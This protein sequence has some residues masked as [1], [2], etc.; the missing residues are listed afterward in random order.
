MSVPTVPQ[1]VA[2]HPGAHAAA[3]ARARVT[4]RAVVLGAVLI[5]LNVY[6]VMMV[7]GIWH[8]GHPSV[9]A[10]PW[11]AVFNLVILLLV[12]VLLRRFAPRH[13]FTQAEL[14][15]IYTMVAIAIMLAG[16]DTLQLGVPNM[17][18]G[19][20]FATEANHWEQLFHEYLPRFLTVSDEA[21]LK[22]YYSGDST[23]YTREHLAAW[24][25]PALWW[26]GIVLAVGVVMVGLNV[27]MRRQWTENERLGYPIVQLPLAMTAEGGSRAFYASRMLW[28]GIA[29]AA[30]IDLSNGLHHFW[31]AW[32]SFDVRH[33]SPKHF[34]DTRPWGKPWSAMG[35]ID[36]PLYP[37][38]IALGF[39]I[40]LDLCFSMWFFFIVRK[41]MQV[42]AVALPLRM[43]PGLP[44]FGEQSFGAWFALGVY[45]LWVARRHLA[46]LGRRLWR[47]ALDD[48]AAEGDPMSYRTAVAA[49]GLG[50]V[51]L[52]WV[53]MKAG[54][55]LPA[56]LL[57]YGFGFLIH[58]TVTRVRA[59]LG[60]PA[61][62]MAG[63]MNAVTLG[64]IFAG[65][66]GLG[67]RSLTIF[68]LFWWFTGRGYR[69]TP[70]PVQLEGFK[71]AEVSGAE[72]QRL[73]VGMALAFGL[74]AFFTYWSA[75]HLTYQYGTTPLVG[76]NGGQWSEL[77]SWLN[78]PKEPSWQR[79]LFIGLGGAATVGMMWMRMNFLWWPLHPAGYALG[80]LFGT[81]YFW[82]CLMIA[83][84][85]K[86]AILR[87][88][89]HKTHRN[90]VPMVYGVI[91]G[92]YFVGAFW[93]A[94][95]V[96]LKE[97]IY[98]FSPG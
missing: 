30:A 90:F 54:M 5:P 6:W 63:N 45:G 75:I 62:E 16:H 78:Y 97:R 39:L 92:E 50:L 12:N 79:M 88:G 65:T 28:L 68:P 60:P 53:T 44:Y 2:E 23:L 69:T 52:L 66:Q 21:V 38:C 10:L 15:T 49:M 98:D 43:M 58:L 84:L 17:S 31:P 81:D 95:S 33:D 55:S 94:L 11:G 32:F 83:W 59:E 56:T 82:S 41:L 73:A 1:P 42:W 22:P 35:R 19:W 91:L 80:A 87:W 72:P 57:L 89:G 40:P 25:G 70:M 85:I 7:E 9:M 46:R 77:A 76:H 36:F 93:S 37:F 24:V 14:I 3:P 64:T 20:W 13:A 18:Y 34:I 48:T 61:H 47:G 86:W 8:S 27:I 96:I 51:F 26:V 67:A 74:G 4:V 71:M 29:I